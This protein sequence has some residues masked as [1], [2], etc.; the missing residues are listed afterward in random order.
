MNTL[1]SIIIPCYNSSFYIKDTLDSIFLQDYNESVEVIVIDDNSDDTSELENILDMFSDSFYKLIF[2]KN[3]VNV[4]GGQARNLGINASA[5]DFICFLDSDDIWLPNKIKEQLKIYTPR[6]ILTSKVK[7]GGDINS[8]DV[9]PKIVKLDSEPVS[10]AL[11]VNSKLIQTSTFFMSSDIAKE[12]MFNPNLPRHQ[13]YDFLLRAESLG[14]SIIQ[15]DTP[16]SFWR[17]EDASSNRFLKKKAT[18]EFF[19]EWFLEYKKYMTPKAQVSYISKNIFSAC[20][21][22]KK[23]KLLFSFLFDGK[24][25]LFNIISIF[26]HVIKWRL[27]KVF[28]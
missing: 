12:V 21:I 23:F 14:Y 6:T 9:L 7:K 25:G 4:G 2:I 8:A 10:E 19:I 1:V 27:S 20:I 5:G 11:F 24:F 18:P 17:V 13:D 26:Y 15:D 28:R 22:T 16:T 3:E